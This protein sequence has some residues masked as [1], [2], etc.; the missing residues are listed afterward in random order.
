M[1]E[2][3]INK[4]IENNDKLKL[5]EEQLKIERILKQQQGHTDPMLP[6]TSSERS[7]YDLGVDFVTPIIETI[8][9]DM[10][11]EIIQTKAPSAEDLEDGGEG[12]TDAPVITI[13][14]AK[15]TKA[16]AT[17]DVIVKV[18]HKVRKGA[19]A[20]EEVANALYYVVVM[21]HP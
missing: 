20:E 6:A 16:A 3:D 9:D 12:L 15:T 13:D 7:S 5:K 17:D 14:D 11:F 19:A 10:Q 21:K 2:S 4:T 8:P 1:L 18:T